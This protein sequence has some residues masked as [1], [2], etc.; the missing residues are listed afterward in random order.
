V[1]TVVSDDIFSPVGRQVYE[2]LRLRTGRFGRDRG[3]PDR[4]ALDGD[5]AEDLPRRSGS[6]STRESGII[7]TSA[8]GDFSP[9][10]V[11]FGTGFAYDFGSK[12]HDFRGIFGRFGVCFSYQIWPADNC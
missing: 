1:C 6:G 11:I 10:N 5:P 3:S 2:V 4:S 8:R 12:K 9:E 7:H